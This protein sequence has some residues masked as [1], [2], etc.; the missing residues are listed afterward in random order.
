M[1][2]DSVEIF[3]ENQGERSFYIEGM[4]RREG[5]REFRDK[6]GWKRKGEI[7]KNSSHKYFC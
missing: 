6:E 4:R 3:T 2:R 5:W 1:S 7:R